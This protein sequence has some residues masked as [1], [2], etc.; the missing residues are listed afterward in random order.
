MASILL[1]NHKNIYNKVDNLLIK[2]FSFVYL[3]FFDL[4]K[5]LYVKANFSKCPGPSAVFKTVTVG[6]D[7][8]NDFFGHFSTDI[9][10]VWFL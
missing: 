2:S 5:I 10:F 6:L 3:K 4:L 7:V 8:K 9:N 1:R